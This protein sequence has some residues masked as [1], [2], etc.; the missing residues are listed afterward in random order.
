MIEF[1]EIEKIA[2]PPAPVV[3]Q[4]AAWWWWAGAVVLGLILLVLAAWG[5]RAFIRRAGLPGVPPKPEKLVLREIRSLRKRAASLALPEFGAALSGIVRAFLH[6]RMGMLARFATTEEILGKSRRRG[7][8]PPPPPVVSAFTRVLEDCDALKFS[9]SPAAD[10][11]NLLQEAE[12]AVAAVHTALQRQPGMA[13][14][15]PPL[16]NVPH[17]SAS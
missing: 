4:A 9:S 16:P 15:L 5:L 10:R 2:E 14:A 7:H 12:S 13:P 1:P 11:E 6:R 17:A 8:E 3:E